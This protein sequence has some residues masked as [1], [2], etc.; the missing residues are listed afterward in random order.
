MMGS[1]L[2]SQ[3]TYVLNTTRQVQGLENPWVFDTSHA[4]RD[5]HI[6]VGNRIAPIKHMCL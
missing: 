5:F 4:A 1:D 3:L 6:E 2:T